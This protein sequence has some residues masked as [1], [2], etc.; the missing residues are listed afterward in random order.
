VFFMVLARWQSRGPSARPKQGSP[1]GP[2]LT[3]TLR[4]NPVFVEP[5]KRLSVIVGIVDRIDL[6]A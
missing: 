4:K 2:T 3:P 1:D 5:S 6:E